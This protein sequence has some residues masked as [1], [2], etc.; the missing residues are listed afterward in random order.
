[1]FAIYLCVFVCALNAFF[2]MVLSLVFMQRSIK[3]NLVLCHFNFFFFIRLIRR[4]MV[5]RSGRWF[6]LHSAQCLCPGFFFSP[7]SFH[8]FMVIFFI[9]PYIFY[10]KQKQKTIKTREEQEKK[11][12]N[13]FSTFHTIKC[14]KQKLMSILF[15]F[16]PF[17]TFCFYPWKAPFV[18]TCSDKH[19]GI[20][21]KSHMTH[22]HNFI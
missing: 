17:E 20:I 9:I 5:V 19:S 13:P 7:L 10:G 21:E 3:F 6:R 11:T 2:F 4:F 18:K 8:F 15:S 1:M 12:C 22:S 14:Q 16:F